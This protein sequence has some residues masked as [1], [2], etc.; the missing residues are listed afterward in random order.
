MKSLRPLLM[1]ALALAAAFPVPAEDRTSFQTAGP[2][3]PAVDIGSDQVMVYGVNETFPARLQSWKEQG[4]RPGFMTGISW[5]GY[6]AYYGADEKRVVEEVQTDAS[7]KRFMHGDSTT[8]GY[9]V[10]T[11]AYLEFLKEYLNP[12]IDAGIDSFYLEEPEYW[13][14]TGWSEGFKRAWREYYG[15]P[16]LA[17]DSSVEAQFKASRLKYELYF[18]ALSEVFRHIKDRA[19][20]QGRQAKCYVPTHSL[21][22]YAQWRIVSP[23]SHLMD[24][25]IADGY[26]AQVWTGTARTPNRYQGVRRERTF[27][28]AFLEYG[29][30]LSMVRPTRRT[31][32]FLAD[33]VEDDPRHTWSDYEYNYK[34]T[35][36]ASLLWPEVSQ[37]E[38]MPWPDR[39]FKGQYA[40][41]EGGTERAG[42][43]REY[44]TQLLAAINALNDMKQADYEFDTGTRGIGVVVS[45]TLMFQRA[46][47][48]PSDPDLAPVHALALP[49]LKHGVPIE[50]VQLENVLVPATLKPYQVL[51]MTYEGQKPLRPEYH[52]A[53]AQWV[54]NGGALI[55]VGDGRDP[56][57]AVPEWWNAQGARATTPYDDLLARL[58]AG[59]EC[60]TRTCPTGKGF[61]RVLAEDP[62]AIQMD[63]EGA[64]RIRGLVHDALSARGST[65]NTQNYLSLRRGPYVVAM[66]LDESV[67]GPVHA[68]EGPFVDL[69]D[70]ALALID[71]KPLA[72]GTPALL[73]SLTWAEDHLANPGVV[74]ASTRVRDVVADSRGVS[75]DTRG[76]LNTPCFMVLR[77]PEPPGTVTTDPVLP[78]E[79]VW[80][81]RHSLLRLSFENQA[82]SIRVAVPFRDRLGSGTAGSESRQ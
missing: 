18:N 77:L 31:V 13:A 25:D 42:I 74:A 28:G 59:E 37:F 29:Q 65:L 5:G 38:V 10:P 26:I 46:K 60:R 58:G 23:E 16:W 52:E 30:M 80:D 14:N 67:D 64:N 7:G 82:R 78:V 15:T 39:I 48:T 21:L 69:F 76:P 4:Y 47:P 17:P 6:D 34:L 70:P 27:E 55:L 43:S 56:Y 66:G 62:A 12:A 19:A 68:L 3:D 61:L 81:A 44:A 73:Y 72:P 8:V 36:V 79:Q 71:E 20:A 50:P 63:P 32:W 41:T 33:P 57:H 24:L 49:L 11:P 9:N 45:D 51:L 22:S 35:L 2:Y 1:G 75:F 40:L 54:H 53:L